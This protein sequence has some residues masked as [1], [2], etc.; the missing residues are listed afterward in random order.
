MQA[1]GNGIEVPDFT[2]Q[3][4]GAEILGM[5]VPKFLNGIVNWFKTTQ[6]RND[7]RSQF[8]IGLYVDKLFAGLKTADERKG[9]VS[10]VVDVLLKRDQDWRTAYLI[11]QLSVG[12]ANPEKLRI[13]AGRRLLDADRLKLRELEYYKAEIAALDTPPQAGT[14]RDPQEHLFRLVLRLVT[15]CQWGFLRRSIKRQY[16]KVY[17]RRL[18]WIFVAT[19]ALLLVTLFFHAT[20][21]EIQSNASCA[22]EASSGCTNAGETSEG[23]RDSLNLLGLSGFWLALVAG[24][25]GAAFSMISQSSKRVRE[26]TLDDIEAISR[27]VQMLIRVSLG[28]GG[29]GILYFIFKASLID[30][31]VF[32]NL[33]SLGF[34]KMK[35]V[36]ASNDALLGTFIPNKDLAAL[37]VWSFLAGFSERLVPSFLDRIETSANETK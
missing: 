10:P 23:K 17:N 4:E 25:F 21:L 7:L 18:Y 14:S 11:E 19:F 13:E 8:M 27:P 3:N 15:D 36:E 33:D 24:V 29:A 6:L 16:A 31:V 34:A 5:K 35:T 37:M 9:E 1:D 30:G 12:V 2:V 32:P 20:P 22:A 28:A 26:A